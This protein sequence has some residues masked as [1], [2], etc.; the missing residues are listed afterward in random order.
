MATQPPTIDP[1]PTPAIQRGDRATFSNRVDAFIRWLVNAA[2][3]FQAVATN[4]FNNA[5]E[6]L[7]SA[8]TAT[9]SAASA[10]TAANSASQIVGAGPWVSGKIYAAGDAAI[11]NVNF[12]TYRRRTAGSSTT[13]PAND[14][15]N[16]SLL[17]ANGSFIP[18]LASVNL[19]NSGVEIDLSKG[20]FFKRTQNGHN[21]L[22]F[23]NLPQQGFSFTYE[24][25]ILAGLIIL[26][27]TVR[28]TDD[29]P[30]SFAAGKKH[31]L[32][33]TTSDNGSTWLMSAATNYSA[34]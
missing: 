5:S 18:V 31:L 9:A 3:Q 16:W 25:N 33:F 17:V 4:V 21:T 7:Q 1:V 32:M 15:G 27:S 14:L 26:P 20:N 24:V 8:R 13:D 23:T 2:V 22:V 10:A 30:Y 28:M 12:Q 29:L 6:A 11:S 34:S 19:P